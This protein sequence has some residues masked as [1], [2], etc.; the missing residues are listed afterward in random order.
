MY[1]KITKFL[2]LLS[3]LFLNTYCS[4]DDRHPIPDVSFAVEVP[5]TLLV[6]MGVNTSM[7]YT[8]ST[9]AGIKGI[10][11]FKRGENEYAAY[12]RLCPNYPNDNCALDIDNAITATCTCCKSKFSLIFGT[13]LEGVAKYPLKQYETSVIGG[14]LSIMN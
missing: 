3:I 8:G 10:I 5:L 9:A 13:P 1:S 11:I 14:R 12:E 2:F 6:Q 4:K 7:F